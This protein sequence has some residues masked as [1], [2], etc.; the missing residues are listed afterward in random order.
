MLL[1][2]R[3]W[4]PVVLAVVAGFSMVAV[5]VDEASACTSELKDTGRGGSV[6]VKC[7]TGGKSDGKTDPAPV[8]RSGKT[9][10]GASKSDWV[11]PSRMQKLLGELTADMVLIGDLAKERRTQDPLGGADWVTDEMRQDRGNSCLGRAAG[12][13]ETAWRW[14]GDSWNTGPGS[15]DAAPAEPAAPVVERPDPEEAARTAIARL[16]FTAPS[17]GA[18]PNQEA[19][20]LEIDVPVGHPVWLWAEGGTTEDQTVTDEVEDV[21]V[22]LSITLD[23]MVYDMG[24]GQT[25]TC[26]NTGTEWSTGVEPGSASPNCGHTYEEMGRYTLSATAYWTIT[27]DADGETGTVEES[28]TD[29]RSWV[30]GEFQAVRR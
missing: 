6:S 13:V 16:E 1:T 14:T 27:W 21:S 29:T 22:S 24:D 30:V 26:R 17:P 23:R 28:R 25:V 15:C 7:S 20:G 8:S 11:P 5:G 2:G 3:R 10:S 19:N 18:G 9:S 12:G 4:V